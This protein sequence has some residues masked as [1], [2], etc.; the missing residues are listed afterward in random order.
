MFNKDNIDLKLI[1][2]F[3]NAYEK[4]YEKGEITDLELDRILSLI[5]S[6]KDYTEKEF[7]EKLTEI[8]R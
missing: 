8:F 4:L 5:D 7:K 3:T 1:L 6:Y 2:A